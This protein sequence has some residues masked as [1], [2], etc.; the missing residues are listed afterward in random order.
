MNIKI[1]SFIKLR[2]FKFANRAY[3]YDVYLK[4]WRKGG[5]IKNKLKHFELKIIR[6][7]YVCLNY[8]IINL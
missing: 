3:K 4:L 1:L 5:E 8:K 6:F 7:A 2:G